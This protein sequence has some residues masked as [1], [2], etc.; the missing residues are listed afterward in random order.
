MLIGNQTINFDNKSRFV[1]P[2]Y[3]R[4]ELGQE[5]IYF[6]NHNVN[7]IEIYN[8]E[9]LEEKIKRMHEEKEKLQQLYNFLSLMK[10]A[11]IDNNG[12]LLIDK[13]IL[14]KLEIVNNAILY[15]AFD[16]LE[17]MQC[18]QYESVIN[19]FNVENYKEKVLS[20]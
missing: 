9:Y 8:K 17:I 13:N 20:I 16:H 2:S 7:A 14:K 4:D 10:K 6:N 11:S 19:S 1:I 5:V 3:L 18:A 12:R 15:G